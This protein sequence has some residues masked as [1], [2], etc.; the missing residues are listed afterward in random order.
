MSN[1]ELATEFTYDAG[2]GVVVS[3]LVRQVAL[4]SEPSLLWQKIEVQPSARARIEISPQISTAGVPGRAL[5][6]GV[7]LGG[8]ADRAVLFQSRG[9]LSQVGIAVQVIPDR[10]FVWQ[11]RSSTYSGDASEG[12]TYVF[13]TLG[14]MVS[15]F[16]HPEPDIEAI[17]LVH[18][19]E[20]TG[21]GRLLEENRLE[22]NDLWK[23][24]VV[25]NG[26]LEDQRAL[27]A[28]FFYL[29][30]SNHRSNLNGMA[31]FGLSSSRWYLGHSFWDTETWS[32]LPIL[33]SSPRAAESLLLFRRR[34]LEAARKAAALFGYRGAQFPWEAAPTNGNEVTPVFAATGWAEQHSVPDVALAFWQYQ[35]ATDDKAFLAEATWPVLKAVAE[36]IESRGT[37]TQ[38]GF[39]ILNIMGPDEANNGLNNSAY[40][41]LAC[42]LVMNAAIR[43]ARAMGGEPP[44]VWQ[45]IATSMYLPV[46][47]QG[48]LTIAEDSANDAFGDVSYLLPF[49]VEVDESVLKRTWNTYRMITSTKPKIAFAKAAES[50]LVAVMGDRRAAA[51]LFRDSWQPDWL[52][53]FGMMR[54]AAPRTDGCFLTNYGSLL[55][56]AMLGFTGL[57]V[58]ERE[59]NKFEATLP[60]NWNSIEIERIYIRGQEKRVSA[61]H[62]KKAR[63]S[64]A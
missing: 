39:E 19:G 30:S 51:R 46:N 20:Q 27:D 62:G 49:G 13:H 56:T 55:R 52:E 1:G 44:P 47:K 29:H 9:D 33:L 53:P 63:I 5:R 18:R 2:N 36:W 14:S 23:S 45:R 21:V 37:H 41:N 25:L 7:P 61:S 32:F 6:D 60:E 8:R 57:R 42:R 15:S 12:T 59:W 35:L 28:A 58:S 10:S 64:G 54:E 40:V 24:R 16:Y 22:W 26:N 4:R 11:E 34:G 43:C 48:V 38:R 3:I 50:S 17:R 31:P